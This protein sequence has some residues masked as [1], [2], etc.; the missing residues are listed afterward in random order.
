MLVS[1]RTRAGMAAATVATLGLVAGGLAPA[2]TGVTAE[3]AA[4]PPKITVTIGKDFKKVVKPANLR[5][6][7]FSVQLN[8]RRAH[9]TL[10]FVKFKKGYSFKQARADLFATF[11][12]D[13]AA[14]HRVNTKSIFLG[15]LGGSRGENITG[16]VVLPRG[17]IVMYDFGGNDLVK[18]GVLKIGGP[19]QFRPEPKVNGTVKALDMA[20]WGGAKTLP[21]KGTLRFK[22]EATDSP[23]FM[24]LQH[25]AAGT[26]RDEVLKCIN[27]PECQGD[28]F[29]EGTAETEVVSPGRSQT[30]DY[31][32]PRGT[33]VLMCFYPDHMTGAPHAAMGMVRIIKL[34]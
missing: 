10:G 4:P 32:L 7:R 17:N 18:V 5:A 16:S 33:Y 29:R 24:N 9:V 22:N 3:R 8:V 1:V 12:G 25:V 6:G 31:D 27:D 34:T 11:G 21:H 14:L 28:F 26:T 20:R 15:G 2:A 23:H 19:K 30:L 13:L